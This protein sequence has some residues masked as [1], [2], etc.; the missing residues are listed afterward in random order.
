M[1]AVSAP[2]R[3]SVCMATYNGAAY[4]EEQLVSILDQLGAED[5]VV[6]VDDASTDDTVARVRALGD[7]RVE[8]RETPVNRG[9][10][11][12]FEDALS[13]ARGDVVL[14]S[15]QDDVWPAGR[16]QAMTAALSGAMVVAGNLSLLGS[17]APMPGP[18]GQADWRLP[19]DERRRFRILAALF[20]SNV[21]YFGSAMGVRRDALA[22]VLPFPASAR[23]LPDA[24]IAVNGLLNRSIAHLDEVV[25]LRRIHDHNTS[26]RRRAWRRVAVG[27]WL[28]LRMVAEARRRRRA[29]PS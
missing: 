22:L 27:R 19:E 21:P 5:E 1:T 11:A 29:S 2:G 13:A 26:G 25:V 15:D 14:L 10:A 18:F 23:E 28:F 6:V 7:P 3:V 20:A 24:W 16:V 17:G 4:V 9:Y 8:V 12:A